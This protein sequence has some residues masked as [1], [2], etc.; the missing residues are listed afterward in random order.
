MVEPTAWAVSAIA[1]CTLFAVI[2]YSNVSAGHNERMEH[3][4]QGN[5]QVQNLGSCG[6]HW[7]KGDK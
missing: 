2:V 5:V 3:I 1:V 7:V 4:I 6:F